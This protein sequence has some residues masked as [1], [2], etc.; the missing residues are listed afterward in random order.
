MIDLHVSID[1]SLHN[2][3]IQLAKREKS[4]EAEI[5]RRALENYIQSRQQQKTYEAMRSYAEI[6]SRYS[7]EFV[8]ETDEMVVKQILSTTDR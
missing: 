4:N 2:D 5:V 7:R 6:M 8:T 3:L 1:N